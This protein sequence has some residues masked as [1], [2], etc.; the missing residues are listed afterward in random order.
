MSEEDE[1]VLGRFS[2]RG[3]GAIVTGAARGLGNAMAL[4]LAEAGADIVAVDVEPLDAVREAIADRGVRCAT[5]ELDLRALT[6]D[7]AAEL[8]TW[9]RSEL[10]EVSVLVNNAGMIKRAPA[11][12]TSAEDWHE[13]I[14]LNLTAPF[15]LAQAFARSLLRDGGRGSIINV[16]SMNSFQGGMEVVSYAASK[17]GLLGLTRALANEWTGRGVRVN[18]IAPGY[19]STELT[20]ALREQPDSYEAFRARMPAGR[21]GEPDDLTGAVVFLASDAS[22]YVSGSVIAV[23]GG[24]LSR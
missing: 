3:K 6:P 15:F 11:A 2:L 4:A 1:G 12:E 21:W 14:G 23:D 17:H 9:S 13:V 16:V 7:V 20:A 22:H 5:R 8:M 10:G 19:M 24:W 18:G